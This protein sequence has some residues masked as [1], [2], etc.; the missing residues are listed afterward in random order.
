MI[1]IGWF[2]ELFNLKRIEEVRQYD[3][4]EFAHK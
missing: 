1:I 4:G 2:A 3:C